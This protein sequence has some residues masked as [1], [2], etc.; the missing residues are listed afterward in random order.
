MTIPVW[1]LTLPGVMTLDMAGPAE[2]LRLAGPDVGLYY[3]GPEA[4]VFSSTRMTLG[5]ILPL[6]ECLPSGSI[7][8]VPGLENSQ[9]QLTLPAATEAC[10]WLRRQ[11]AAIQRREIMLVCIC[12][13]A[14][15][16]ARAGLLDG[17]L[18]TTH[19]QLLSR[20]RESAPAARVLDNRIF[21]ED[22]GIWTSAGITTGI[23]L[24]LHLVNRLFGPQKALDIA[25][26]M[27]VWFRRSGNDPQLS[28]WLRYRNHLHPAIHR[29]Q[30]LISQHP[31]QH[32][33]LMQLAQ[34]AHVSGRHLTRLFRQHLGVTVHTYQQQLQVAVAEQ[35]IQ[36]GEGIEKAAL[37][38]GFSSAR[39]YR[40]TAL[41]LSADNPG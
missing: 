4:T 29:A 38:A 32:W 28:P 23:D 36:Q 10:L 41:R 39:H 3:T 9:H 25:R 14:L 21:V 15:L 1:F 6:P 11:R 13:G 2:T 16:A 7:L 18:C 26:E 5:N 22:G 37:A 33:S 31:E 27:V 24:A 8:I 20:L 17:V 19:H 12:A 35:R 34:R 40:R 30:D